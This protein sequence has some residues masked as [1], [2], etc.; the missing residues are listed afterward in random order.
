MLNGRVILLDESLAL[1]AAQI[2]QDLKLAM[3]DSLILATTFCL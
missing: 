3:A 1:S 2:S